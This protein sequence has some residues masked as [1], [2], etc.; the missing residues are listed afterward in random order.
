VDTFTVWIAA[1]NSSVTNPN[2]ENSAI[3]LYLRQTPGR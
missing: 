2:Q 1:A 3:N